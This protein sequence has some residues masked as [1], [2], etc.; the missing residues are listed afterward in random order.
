MYNEETVD[1]NNISSIVY[2]AL[3]RVY[4]DKEIIVKGE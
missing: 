1:I 4:G 3:K 2:E